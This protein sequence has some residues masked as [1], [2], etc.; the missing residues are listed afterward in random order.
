MKSRL[1]VTIDKEILRKIKLL[2]VNKECTL[3]KLTENAFKQYLER[4]SKK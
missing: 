3:S 4:D 1:T 2:A